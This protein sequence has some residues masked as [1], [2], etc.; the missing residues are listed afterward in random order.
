MNLFIVVPLIVQAGTYGEHRFGRVEIAG[1]ETPV[2][3]N[4]K[5]FQ[6][7]LLPGTE[8]DLHID[9]QLYCNKPG[10]AFPWHG[11]QIPFR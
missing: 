3:V 2:E 9:M 10:C 4:D 11:D 8:L 6:V 5:T 1:E 7:R